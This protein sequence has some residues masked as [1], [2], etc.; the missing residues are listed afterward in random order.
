LFKE[1]DKQGRRIL[2]YTGK[3]YLPLFEDVSRFDKV[4]LKQERDDATEENTYLNQQLQFE[5]GHNEQLASENTK[6][7]L[8]NSELTEKVKDL[9]ERLY[10]LEKRMSAVEKFFIDTGVGKEKLEEIIKDNMGDSSF[11][12]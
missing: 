3:D 11:S 12:C 1:I 2:S 7:V 4:V 6:L 5:Q 9:E 10:Q 8:S